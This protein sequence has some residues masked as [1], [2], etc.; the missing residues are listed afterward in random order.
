VDVS[1]CLKL[2]RLNVLCLPS[3]GAFDDAK[4]DRLTFFQTA[5][6]LCLNGGKMDENIFA[7]LSAEK[8][9]AFGVIEPFHCSL[10]HGST[11]I[12]CFV[13]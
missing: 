3:L 8:S 12:P 13:N 6:A 7:V 4:L 2:N 9:I 11:R 5:K 10:F 1:N